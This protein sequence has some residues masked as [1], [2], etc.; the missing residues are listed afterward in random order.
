MTR[1]TEYKQI[2]WFKW[3]MYHIV[4]TKCI[5]LFYF[6]LFCL[7]DEVT[8]HGRFRFFQFFGEIH[9]LLLKNNSTIILGSKSKNLGILKP[10]PR[11]R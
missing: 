10:Q 6:V 11:I 3:I 5:V 9:L 8:Y 4:D 2:K 1:K 7:Y